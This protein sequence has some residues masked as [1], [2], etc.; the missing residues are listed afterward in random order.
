MK[1]S[2][3]EVQICK[4]ENFGEM[5]ALRPCGSGTIVFIQ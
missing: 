1:P 2:I 5:S 3:K 4:R